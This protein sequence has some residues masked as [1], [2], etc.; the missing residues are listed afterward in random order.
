MRCSTVTVIGVALAAARTI[1]LRPTQRRL[2]E[3]V[4]RWF[5]YRPSSLT[6]WRILV[7]VGVL[8]PPRVDT[9][10]Q[11]V[12]ARRPDE[13]ARCRAAA[14][15]REQHSAAE[16]RGS[17]CYGLRHTSIG[18]VFVLVS[19]AIAW[20]LE[21]RLTVA[22]GTGVRRFLATP[23]DPIRLAEGERESPNFVET[24]GRPS[25]PAHE[26]H[27]V[28]T[29]TSVGNGRRRDAS[30]TIPDSIVVLRQ[31]GQPHANRALRK[32][33]RP[34]WQ[35]ATVRIALAPVACQRKPVPPRWRQ[36]PR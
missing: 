8:F 6:S 36:N 18:S 1:V 16:T 11:E 23:T 24:M 21:R 12:G 10:A 33:A 7:T 32:V 17:I 31:V 4:R 22:A 28:R 34:R 15:T 29:G 19:S 9:A 25:R 26:A 13:N 2:S 14:L 3:G 20:W 27:R 35:C 5:E 30:S